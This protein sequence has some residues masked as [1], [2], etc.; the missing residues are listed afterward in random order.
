MSPTTK[1]RIACVLLPLWLAACGGGGG[2]GNTASAPVPAPAPGPVPPGTGADTQPPV[3]A[4]TAPSN[5]SSGLTGALKLNASA[6][7][8]L[9]VA[10][11][12]VKRPCYS[13]A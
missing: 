2:G 1:R 3:A 8:T 4:L 6:I 13:T 7:F 9:L 11:V 5:F 10:P 12:T